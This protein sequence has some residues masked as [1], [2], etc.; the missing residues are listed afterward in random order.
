M[1]AVLAF[2]PTTK[3]R[4][5]KLICGTSSDSNIYKIA[6]DAGTNLPVHEHCH[7]E[8][9]AAAGIEGSAAG[10]RGLVDMGCSDVMLGSHGGTH[11]SLSCMFEC[12]MSV[13]VP[14]QAKEHMVRYASLTTY[15]KDGA[16]RNPV[17]SEETVANA[18]VATIRMCV[19]NSLSTMQNDECLKER[20]LK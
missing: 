7:P 3:L 13:S 14:Q 4:L 5:N 11:R 8:L 1:L 19:T 17:T 18:V 9:A 15:R 16:T 12:I 10:E 20:C 6:S 2:G